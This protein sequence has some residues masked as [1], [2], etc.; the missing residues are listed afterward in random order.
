M[1]QKALKVMLHLKVLVGKDEYNGGACGGGTIAYIKRY[2]TILGGT[3]TT[4]REAW[5]RSSR[6]VI[7]ICEQFWSED[8]AYQNGVL[9]HESVHHLGPTDVVFSDGAY[10][11][12]VA[13]GEGMA[14]ELALQQ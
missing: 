3:I 5:R 13:Y 10:V 2:E 12:M 1:F 7:Q 14:M 9:I 6:Y 8:R 11:G 4:E